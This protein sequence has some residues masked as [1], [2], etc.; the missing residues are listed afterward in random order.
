MIIRRPNSK[1]QIQQLV[2]SFLLAVALF[3][4]HALRLFS[5]TWLNARPIDPFVN[6]SWLLIVVM[7][8]GP[9]TLDIQGFYD[10]P[11]DKPTMKSLFQIIR[12]MLYLSLIVSFC[13]IF[14]RLS[15]VARSVP[16]LFIGIATLILLVRERIS[17]WRRRGAPKED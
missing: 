14:L 6:Y 15:L 12:A 8:F 7:L 1:T 2:D 3:V 5:T 10:S 17:I 9:I 11:I 4:A 16:L 13:T